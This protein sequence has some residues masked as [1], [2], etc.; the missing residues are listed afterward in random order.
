MLQP[1]FHAWDY[2]KT[3]SLR[4][5]AVS[6]F[7]LIGLALAGPGHDGRL[8]PAATARAQWEA[9][10]A[11]SNAARAQYERDLAACRATG[12]CVEPN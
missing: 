12:R 5:L 6:S 7:A 3:M 10:V 4:R 11:A 1:S 9:D 2:L 8:S